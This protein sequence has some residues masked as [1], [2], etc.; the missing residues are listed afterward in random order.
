M[1]RPTLPPPCMEC[2]PHGG[3]F[4]A[5]KGGGMER[6]TCPRGRALQEKHRR[7]RKKPAAWFD[8]KAAACGDLS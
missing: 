7:P 6:C 1:K 4:R 5:A 2:Q 8:G 3:Y